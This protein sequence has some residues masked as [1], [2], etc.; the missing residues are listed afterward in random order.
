LLGN[1]QIV[2]RSTV[3]QVA[4]VTY[5]QGRL[6]AVSYAPGSGSVGNNTALS[7]SYDPNTGAQSGISWSFP[8]GQNGLSDTVVRSQLGRILQDTITDGSTPHISTYGYDAASRLVSAAVDAATAGGTPHNQI[9][10]GFGATTGCGNNTAGADGNRTSM[11]DSLDGAAA[12]QVAYCYDNADRLAGTTVTNAPSGADTLLSANLSTTGTTPTLVYDSHGNTTKLSNQTISYDQTDRHASTTT[13][14]TTGATITYTR[15]ATDRIISMTTTPGTGTASTVYYGYTGSGDSP[16]YTMHNRQG[17]SPNYYY[18]IDEHP[19]ALPG[20][21]TLAVQ[22]GGLLWSYPNLHG[23]IAVTTNY[24]TRTGTLAL[25]DPFGQPIDPTTHKIG[26]LTADQAVPADT[27]TNASYGWA[28]GAQKLYQHQSDIAITEMG[29]RQYS[30][31]LGRFLSVDPVAGGN[32]NDYNYPNDPINMSDLSGQTGDWGVW[33]DILSVAITVAAIVGTTLAV[34]ACAA[35]VVCGIVAAAAIGVAA[36]VA[37]YAATTKSA[38]YSTAGFVTSGV[39]GG[40]LGAVSGGAGGAILRP[41]A[42]AVSK[43]GKVG[44]GRALQLGKLN[45]RLGFDAKPHPFGIVGPRAHWQVN[46]WTSG[47]SGSGGVFRLPVWKSYK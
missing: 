14:G 17:T 37:T 10:Y 9:G 28:G 30:A 19:L 21:V 22:A 1:P 38:D 47:R 42:T 33:G 23:D 32:A 7:V 8:F 31:A 40:A 6:T 29:A 16:D 39:V 41:I 25:Y 27:T 26:T 13:P 34:A 4:A 11:S 20:G 12:T 15:D 44:L 35:S 3:Q 43:G 5:T 45:V 36:G 24:S 2:D 18:A 46:W